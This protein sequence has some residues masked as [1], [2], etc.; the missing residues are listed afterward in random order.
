VR[1]RASLSESIVFSSEESTSAVFHAALIEQLV[2]NDLPDYRGGVFEG[3]VV[4][5]ES[6]GTSRYSWLGFNSFAEYN[7]HYYGATPEGVYLLEGED[8][9][10]TDIEAFVLSRSTDFGVPVDKHVLEGYVNSR[11]DNN[12]LFKTVIED[13][14]VYTYDLSV[15]DEALARRR[16]SLG[17]GASAV[18]WQ[19]AIQNFEGG[20]FEA[21]S[22][23]VYV[24]GLKRRFR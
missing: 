7:G 3:W 17:R 10:G 6:S 22:F 15:D 13:L 11:G 4:N 5:V 9:A 19:F 16:V 24:A 1:K 23:S 8:D 2:F 20:D 21:D 12:L 18:Y 14:T